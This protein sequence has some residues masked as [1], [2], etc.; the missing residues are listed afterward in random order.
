MVLLLVMLAWRDPARGGLGAPAHRAPERARR[1]GVP[2]SMALERGSAFLP[3]EA[4]R[5]WDR[6]QLGIG[7]VTA[8]PREIA[9]GWDL[10]ADGHFT[11]ARTAPPSATCSSLASYGWL[12]VRL[13][14]SEGGMRSPGWPTR[15]PCSSS[16]CRPARSRPSRASACWR[17]R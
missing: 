3:F 11:A 5:A 4:Q 16:R 6:G 10:V 2:G 12:L 7:L 14:R 8:A 17:S 15:R 1:R 13:W 9:A